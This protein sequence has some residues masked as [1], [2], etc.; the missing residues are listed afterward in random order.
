MKLTDIQKEVLEIIKKIDEKYPGRPF[1]EWEIK[2]NFRNAALKALEKREIIKV[3]ESPDIPKYK[4]REEG[5]T[6]YILKKKE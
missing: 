1:T 5:L 4:F 3:V 6:Y 2:V